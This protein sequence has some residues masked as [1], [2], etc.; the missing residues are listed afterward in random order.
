MM[1]VLLAVLLRAFSRISAAV[2]NPEA[3]FGEFD[4]RDQNHG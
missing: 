3:S 2:K 1:H 4:P